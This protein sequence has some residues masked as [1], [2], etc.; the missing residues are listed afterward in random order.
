MPLNSHAVSTLP[1][2]EAECVAMYD[3][4]K[5]LFDA[6]KHS[7]A[8]ELFNRLLLVDPDNPAVCAGLGESLLAQNR[9]VGAALLLR[10]AVKS[11]HAPAA[12][13]LNFGTALHLSGAADEAVGALGRAVEMDATLFTGWQNLAR[14]HAVAGGWA[15]A[16]A[17][18][19]RAL[20]LAPDD[21]AMH[22]DLVFYVDG[23]PATRFED[24]LQARRA[25]ASAHARGPCFDHGRHDRAPGRRIRIGYVSADF[26]HHSLVHAVLG[27]ITRRNRDR[28]DAI[29]YC[30]G[31]PRDEYTH[32]FRKA[33]TAFVDI[34]RMSDEAAARRIRADR[35][36]ILVDL[37]GHTAGHRLG[38]FAR[39]PAPLQASG[40]GS[41]LGTGLAAIDYLVTDR[42]VLAPA[43]EAHIVER[44]WDMPCAIA[45][46]PPYI[47]MEGAW[48]P[49][50][51]YSGWFTFGSFN[52]LGKVTPD[53]AALWAQILRAVPAARLMLKD[54]QL[55]FLSAQHRIRAWFAAEGIGP[56]RLLLV[57]AT[58]HLHHMEEYHKLDVALDPF[59]AGGGI[60]TFEAA[61]MGVPTLTKR[62]ATIPGRITESINRGLGLEDF[63]AASADAYVRRAIDLY[64]HRRH[65]AELRATMR[66][67]LLDTPLG[68]PIAYC[69]AWEGR[70]G[71]HW[72]EF[73]GAVPS[74]TRAAPRCDH[75]ASDRSDCACSETG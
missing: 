67:R 66:K 39:K 13:W 26:H 2:T 6:G 73:C 65:L 17:A 29:L 24:A 11:P 21:A 28:F 15:R 4:A 59:P 33:A 48:P 20:A 36:D 60:T 31:G 55:G 58:D 68:N 12:A 74:Q 9:P 7:A 34:E 27:L 61:W 64:E 63:V 71:E 30:N 56:E 43:D 47:D 1:G 46:A 53:T 51:I 16:A 23:D 69:A 62:G 42:V 37:S 50:H 44:R 35:I 72:R 3:Q 38:V 19:R 25:W 70:A 5:V 22:S 49:P 32:K 45:Y 57:G 10:Q 54:K 18:A 40:W 14:S 8:G 75:M 52:K 41:P